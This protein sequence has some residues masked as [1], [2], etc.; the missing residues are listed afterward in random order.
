[1]HNDHPILTTLTPFQEP[2]QY[3]L[4]LH[5]CWIQPM[6]NF[7][8]RPAFTR[9]IQTLG[10]YYSHTLMNA[11]LS[12]SIRWARGN[13]SIKEKLDSLYD[14]G[15]L[16]GKH[17][18]SLLFDELSA[19]G[20]SVPTVQALLLLSAQECSVGNSAQAWIY[21]GLAFRIVDHLGICI[22]GRRYPGSAQLSDEDVEIRHRL[23]WSCYLWDKLVSLYL[24][25]LPTLKHSSVSPPQSVC[26]WSCFPW[27]AWHCGH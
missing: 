25:R 3:L 15:A 8:Y 23:F 22:D 16:F 4:N 17:A 19:G 1:M 9:D 6:F 20:Q 2:F 13:P 14:G 24:G 18:R 5:W 10:P 21:S 12:H 27:S 26:R 11:I 7:I